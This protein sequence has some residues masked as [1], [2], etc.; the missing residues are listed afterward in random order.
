MGIETTFITRIKNKYDGV[1]AWNEANPTLL[2]GEIAVVEVEAAVEDVNGDAIP[3]ILLKVGDGE[4][5]FKQL[6]FLSGYAADVYDWAKAEE[7]PT[8]NADEITGLAAYI[9]GKVQD[10]DTQYKLEPDATNGHIIKL[11][12]KTLNGQWTEA[13]S[14]TTVDTVYDDTALVGRVTGLEN[15]VG[16]DTVGN[17][18]DAKINALDLANTYDAKG[19]AAGALGDAKEYTDGKFNPLAERVTANEN[20]LTNLN[21]NAE[22]A[23]SIDYK[24]AQAVAAIMQNPDATMNSINELVTWCNDHASDALE[25]SNKV[26]ANE[27]DITALENLVGTTAVATQITDAIAAALK[28][29]GVDK[30]ALATDLTAAIARIAANEQ[31]IAKLGDLAEK[32]EVAEA[33]LAEALATKINAKANDADLAAIAKSGN[34]NDLIQTTGDVLILDCGTSVI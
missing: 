27:G 3:A 18:I 14:I 25:L 5:S 21:A 30:Y 29:D 10:T 7:K 9:A 4:T 31:A 20:A 22:T 34:V 1:Q 24:I 32:D 16:N 15:K 8:Y 28:I 19:A 26:S 12:S 13:G 33:D 2:K 17:Q 11:Y 6:P 23:G